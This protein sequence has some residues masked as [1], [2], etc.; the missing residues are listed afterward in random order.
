MDDLMPDPSS[1]K[2]TPL[3]MS[4]DMAP[5]R[6]E[7]EIKKGADRDEPPIHLTQPFHQHFKSS[8]DSPSVQKTFGKMCIHNGS[9]TFCHQSFLVLLI[10]ERSERVYIGTLGSGKP[11]VNE[12]TRRVM[13]GHHRAG[14]KSVDIAK[15]KVPHVFDF[16][17]TKIAPE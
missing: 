7:H 10:R 13:I 15:D 16:L 8:V 6:L 5:P 9:T 3:G 4:D 11:I 1:F 2:T 14:L 17:S 12:R